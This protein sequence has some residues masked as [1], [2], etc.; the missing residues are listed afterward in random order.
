MD[1][2]FYNERFDSEIENQQRQRG[3][4]QEHDVTIALTLD[5]EI[6]RYLSFF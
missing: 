6:L 1:V 5:P 4:L 3:P 2:G